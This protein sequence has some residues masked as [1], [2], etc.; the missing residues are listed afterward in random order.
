MQDEDYA[1]AWGA[2]YLG[3][4]R[5]RFRLWAPEAKHV[6]LRLEGHEHEMPADADGWHELT[7][8]DVHPGAAY[9]YVIADGRTVP[10]PASRAQRGTVTG[11]SLVVDH[12]QYRWQYPDWAGRPWE[13]TVYYELHVGTFTPEGTY[14][15]AQT[16]LHHLRDLGITT[17]ELMPVNHFPGE[18]GWGYDPVLIYAPHPAYGTPDELKAFIDAAHGLGLSVVLDVVY[19]HFGPE[20]NLLPTYAPGFFHPERETP[21]GVAIAYEKAPVRRFFLD[22]ALY[23]LEVYRFD[24]LRFD[25]TID[26]V[27]ER[28]TT[29]P[30]RRLPVSPA[31]RAASSAGTPDRMRPRALRVAM[32]MSKAS[33]CAVQ[34]P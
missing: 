7:L 14:A 13:E 18:R 11:P 27:V 20:G 15:A 5:A 12:S 29:E 17:I 2:E 33:P 24:G 26:G 22:N 23:W 34:C 10:D 6:R 25:A 30:A 9:E 32:P 4:G 8:D 3:A 31:A 19:N 28:A 21:W 16:R 1:P